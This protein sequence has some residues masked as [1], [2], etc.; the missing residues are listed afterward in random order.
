MKKEFIFEL[1]VTD[2]N[3]KLYGKI[4]SFSLG[5]LQ[6]QMHK[7]EKLIKR[8]SF[9]C[10]ICGEEKSIYEDSD[11]STSEDICVDCAKNK[12]LPDEPPKE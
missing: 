7:I 8:Y 12:D 11:I 9:T 3:N 4:S 2:E 1:K 5:C 10:D 6:E